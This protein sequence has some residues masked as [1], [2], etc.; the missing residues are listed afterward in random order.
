MPLRAIFYT[1]IF[2]IKRHVKWHRCLKPPFI[3]NVWLMLINYQQKG[4]LPP[5]Y[6]SYVMIKMAKRGIYTEWVES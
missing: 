5:Q 3:V 4:R 2:E 6:K 1:N